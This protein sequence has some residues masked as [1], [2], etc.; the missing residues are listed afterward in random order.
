MQPADDDDDF[1][2]DLAVVF[3]VVIY[4]FLNI[5]IKFYTKLE[6]CEDKYRQ[7][8]SSSSGF[9]RTR[10][11]STARSMPLVEF[12]CD[13]RDLAF[14]EGRIKKKNHRQQEMTG[15]DRNALG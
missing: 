1:V 6:H 3:V 8:P 15:K 10:W 13:R 4:L 14:S 12:L 7:L 11:S 5:I 9:G 2:V